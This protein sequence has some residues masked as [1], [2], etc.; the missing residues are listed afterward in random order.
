MGKLRSSYVKNGDFHNKTLGLASYHIKT[1]SRAPSFWS[2]FRLLS[3]LFRMP[4]SSTVLMNMESFKE[5]DCKPLNDNSP[6]DT[7]FITSDSSK[8]LAGPRLPSS[9]PCFANAALNF[10]ICK[11]DICQNTY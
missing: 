9:D 5:G 4:D 3:A 7:S 8:P 2:I 6:A 11:H 10:L 1:Y